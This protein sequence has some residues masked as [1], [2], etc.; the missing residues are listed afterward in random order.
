VPPR[1]IDASTIGL[2]A[3]QLAIA[4][5][6]EKAKSLDFYVCIAVVDR[7][8][9]LLAFARMD[10]APL[11]TGQIAQDKAYTAAAFGVPTHQLWESIRDEP[12][13]VHGVVKADR[14]IIFGGG[15]LLVN[16][17]EVVGAIGVSGKTSP[18]QDQEIAEAGA[19]AWSLL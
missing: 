19:Q 7:S 13:L 11:L 8:G 9:Q 16:E 3:A 2:E 6:I 14:M 10:G 5:A 4:G 17:G 15:V 12:A 1:V 18:G